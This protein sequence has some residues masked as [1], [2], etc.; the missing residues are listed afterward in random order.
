MAVWGTYINIPGLAAS[1]TLTQFSA[2]KFAST[3][4]RVVAVN[5]TTDRA[6]G[7]IQNDPT[8]GEAAEIAGLG[9][10]IGRAGANDIAVG[11]LLGFNSSGQVVDHTTDGRF[12]FAMALQASTAVNDE[13]KVLLT[14]L[15]SYG[16]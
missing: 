11:D 4:G 16:G 7:L 6:I 1:G 3:A 12:I 9:V 10:A 13:V 8:N 14:G 5:A 15:N 2:V